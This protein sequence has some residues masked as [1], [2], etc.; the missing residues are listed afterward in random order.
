MYR[1]IEE[2]AEKG[3][4]NNMYYEKWLNYINIL[5]KDMSFSHV[6]SDDIDV[7]TLYRSKA[8]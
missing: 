1:S 5:V 2:G 7:S 3:V 8:L 6:L 4:A